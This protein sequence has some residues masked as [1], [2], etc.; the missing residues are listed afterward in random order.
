MFLI[1]TRPCLYLGERLGGFLA[2]VS[3]GAWIF[4]VS[5]HHPPDP[6]Q[7]P[8]PVLT[9]QRPCWRVTDQWDAS[10][11][12]PLPNHLNIE[13]CG[14]RDGDSRMRDTLSGPNVSIILM[15]SRRHHRPRDPGLVM[16]LTTQWAGDCNARTRSIAWSIFP[17][18]IFPGERHDMSAPGTVWS[19]TR[20]VGAGWPHEASVSSPD[21]ALSGHQIMSGTVIFRAWM[22]SLISGS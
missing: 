17:C 18:D 8:G 3:Y 1:V 2:P 12:A 6:D 21:P 15:L 10:A 9:N 5:H 13:R 11:P 22:W 16:A 4:I 19:A 14:V 20:A 7:P